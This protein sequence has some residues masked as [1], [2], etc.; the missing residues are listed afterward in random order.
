MIDDEMNL[1]DIAVIKLKDAIEFNEVQ[2]AIQLLN[3]DV[4][5]NE[6]GFILGWGSTTYPTLSY[7][8]TMQKA[9]MRVIPQDYYPKM[10]RFIVHDTQF[11]ALNK[12]GVGPCLGDSGNPL[13]LDGKLAG[14]VSVM[15]PCALGTPDIYTKIYYYVDFIREMMNR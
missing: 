4:I 1:Y 9:A 12:K 13:I 5:D 8:T 10:F 6:I 11:C 14:L 2:S 15:H 7:P 3:R